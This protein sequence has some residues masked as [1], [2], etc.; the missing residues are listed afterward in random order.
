[1]RSDAPPLLPILR[2]RTQAG[3]LTVLL[4]NP[5]LE[6]SQTELAERLGAALTSVIDEVR[7][8]ERAGILASRSVG[9]TRLI[10]AGESIL[11][12][13]L[14]ELVVRAFGP[15]EIVGEEFAELAART[16]VV[17]LAVFGSWAARYLG[18]AGPDPAD[19]DVLV[20]LEDGAMDREPIYAAADRA[21][22]RLGRP[23]NPT[24]VTAARWGRRGHG[25]DPFLDE[26]VSRPIVAVPVLDEAT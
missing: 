21:G 19:I 10:R 22:V 26:V 23:V 11:V 18:E 17:G 4:L 16:E 7:R 9:R 6:L 14:T 3:V 5:E 1:M 24:V 12:G 20:V 15:V 13:P 25:E 2:S 8:L